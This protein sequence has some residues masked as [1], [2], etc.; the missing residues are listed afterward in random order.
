MYTW[1]YFSVSHSVVVAT[2]ISREAQTV[3]EA[4]RFVTPAIPLK[5]LP[6]LI[7]MT[8]QETTIHTF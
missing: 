4:S 6:N 1:R 5:L 3:L 7:S 8:A 2:G